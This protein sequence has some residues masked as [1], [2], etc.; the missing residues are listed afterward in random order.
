MGQ[1]AF[2]TPKQESEQ[3]RSRV[4]GISARAS[5][6]ETD[7]GCAGFRDALAA[8][9]VSPNPSVSVPV[10]RNY[11]NRVIRVSCCRTGKSV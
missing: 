2:P 11:G 4:S 9:P 1:P 3:E 8:I 5:D 7:A 10:S 6:N